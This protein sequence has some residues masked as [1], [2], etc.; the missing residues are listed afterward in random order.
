M[1]SIFREDQNGLQRGVRPNA[2]QSIW[3]VEKIIKRCKKVIQ[4]GPKKTK[5]LGFKKLNK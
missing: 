4:T 2:Q 1:D 3:E 5:S